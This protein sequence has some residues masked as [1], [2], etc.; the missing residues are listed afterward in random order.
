MDKMGMI[1][2]DLTPEEDE[3]GQTQEPKQHKKKASVSQLENHVTKR[4]ADTAQ[5]AKKQANKK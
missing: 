4:V 3:D 1:D 5:D 2:P